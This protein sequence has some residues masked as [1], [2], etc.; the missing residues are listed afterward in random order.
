VLHQGDNKNLPFGSG[1]VWG[2]QWPQ[3]DTRSRRIL[4]CLLRVGEATA[5][6]RPATVFAREQT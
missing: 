5:V 4:S 3:D 1:V 2:E 6:T